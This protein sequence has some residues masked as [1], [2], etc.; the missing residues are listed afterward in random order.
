MTL[1][2]VLKHL[3]ELSVHIRTISDMDQ[4][5]AKLLEDKKEEA[6]A[7]INELREIISNKPMQLA[8]HWDDETHDSIL[9]LEHLIG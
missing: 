9:N 7:F 3:E 6:A 5:D 8:M 1:S 2:E 4:F